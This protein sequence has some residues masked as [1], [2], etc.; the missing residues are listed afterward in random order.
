MKRTKAK[1]PV[2]YK[3]K[4][5]KKR[6]KELLTMLFVITTTKTVFSI[7][8]IVAKGGVSEYYIYNCVSR[9]LIPFTVK[10]A[11]CISVNL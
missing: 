6:L 5:T 10:N 3:Q 2:F 11:V 4:C 8:L 7:A 1:K 9:F